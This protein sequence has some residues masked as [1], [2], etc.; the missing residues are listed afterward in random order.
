MQEELTNVVKAHRKAEYPVSSLFLNRWSPR[1]FADRKVRDEDLYAVL[2]AA[3]WAP[4]ASNEQPWR[5]IVAKSD[6]DLKRF[7]QFIAPGNQLWTR[8]APVLVLFV[9]AT[10]NQKGQANR[11]HAFDTG[12]AWANF[13]LQANQLGLVTHAMGGFDKEMA[14]KLLH[15]PDE[16]EVQALV[17]IGYQGEKDALPE[18]LQ[19]REL[20]NGR[21]PVSERMFEGTMNV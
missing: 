4:S 15:I 8:R 6:E 11:F 19:A 17:A 1:S 3:C 7:D 2:E 9:S 5:F 10:L 16:F 12:A 20:P 18:Q 13:A 21:K 14:R